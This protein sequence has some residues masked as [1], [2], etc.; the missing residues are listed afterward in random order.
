MPATDVRK[1]VQDAAYVSV[2]VGVLAF[3]RAQVARREAQ[4][5]LERQ[6]KDTRDRLSTGA[7]E[8]RETV[9]TT[10]KEAQQRFESTV[11][12]VR[13]RIE[14]VTQQVRTRVEPFADQ[15]QQRLPDSIAKLVEAG[16]NRLQPGSKAAA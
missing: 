5:T 12:D 7:T 4:A 9:T 16:R 11:G 8:A 13:S 10:A 3:Q 14:P 6:V 1:L 2:G 15:V